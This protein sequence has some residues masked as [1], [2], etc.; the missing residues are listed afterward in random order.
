MLASGGGVKELVEHLSQIELV[1]MGFATSTDHL[2]PV[3]ERLLKTNVKLE[4][5]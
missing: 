4:Q 3:A 5:P 1:E 2:L